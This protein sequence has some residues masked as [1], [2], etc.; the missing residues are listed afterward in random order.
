MFS[1]SKVFIID[2]NTDDSLLSYMSF[3]LNRNRNL[4]FSL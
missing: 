2:F 4:K 3:S 1:L